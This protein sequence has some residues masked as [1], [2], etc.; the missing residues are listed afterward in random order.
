VE[1]IEV[2]VVG[3]QPAQAVFQGAPRIVGFRALA[4]GVDRHAEL[5]GEHHLVAPPVEGA[6]E[7]SSLFVL[8]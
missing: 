1:L 4:L 6:A 5:G 2:D 7:N 8:P 3:A